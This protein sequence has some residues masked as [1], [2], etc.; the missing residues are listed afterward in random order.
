MTSTCTLSV[1]C[2]PCVPCCLVYHGPLWGLRVLGLKQKEIHSSPGLGAG[3]T[4]NESKLEHPISLS[5]LV[6]YWR[7]KGIFLLCT[8]YRVTKWLGMPL[9]WAATNRYRHLDRKFLNENF[10]PREADSLRNCFLPESNGE[11]RR[12]KFL[13]YK[14]LY[15]KKITVYFWNK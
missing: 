4:G 8:I 10:W 9:W 12:K 11:F 5:Y 1:A 7:D 2:V 6:I 15:F 3:W 14:L 13:E